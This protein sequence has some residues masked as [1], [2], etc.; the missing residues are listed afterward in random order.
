MAL[1][2]QILTQTLLWDPAALSFGLS[3]PSGSLDKRVLLW[4][5]VSGLVLSSWGSNSPGQPRITGLGTTRWDYSMHGALVGLTR[6]WDISS[7]GRWL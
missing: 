7:I 6:S 2:L 4:D 5:A 3:S 1:A